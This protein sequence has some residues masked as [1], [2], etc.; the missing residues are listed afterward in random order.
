MNI[1]DLKSNTTWQE[2]SNTINNNNNKISLAI[3]TLENATL[4]NKGYFTTLEKLN[5]A[6][7]NP[8]VGS[9]A[10][11]GT[12]EPYAIYI[13]ENGVWVDSGYTGGDEIVARITTDRI[14]DGAV[15]SEKIATSAFDDTLSVSGKIAPADV[16]G[17]KLNE[18]E[19]DVGIKRDITIDLGTPIVGYYTGSKNKVIGSVE[20]NGYKYNPYSLAKYE[21]CELEVSLIEPS[22]STTR[23]TALCDDSGKIID[24]QGEGDFA[25]N[26]TKIFTIGHNQYLY[27][28]RMQNKPYSVVVK[29][30]TGGI[31][32]SLK[33]T[34]EELGKTKIDLNDLKEYVGISGIQTDT[35]VG[36]YIYRTTLKKLESPN[37][38][39]SNVIE[40]Q[41]GETLHFSCPLN[42]AN[43]VSIL[44][45]C[46]A[47]GTVFNECLIYDTD[48]SKIGICEF[49]YTS[50]THRFVVISCYTYYGGVISAIIKKNVLN[51]IGG[52]ELVRR[53]LN[54]IDEE[55]PL[56]IIKDG[57]GLAG[58]IKSFACIGDSYTEGNFN[59]T[60]GSALDKDAVAYYTYPSVLARITGATVHNIGVSGSTAAH[61]LYNGR[62]I[63]WAKYAEE[64]GFFNENNKA[65][66]YYI[67]LGLND[68]GYFGTFDGDVDTDI[69]TTDYMQCNRETS[70]GAIGYIVG[71]I[72]SIQPN[73]IIFIETTS[74]VVSDTPTSTHYTEAAP[75]IRQIANKLDLELVDME[76]YFVPDWVEAKKWHNMYYN[77]GHPNALGYYLLTQARV[78]Y[79]DW[80][81]RNNPLRY[82][83]IAFIGTDMEYKP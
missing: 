64:R 49:E 6:I 24:F 12:S 37:L 71:K 44:T 70:V 76:K 26:P 80:L 75:K 7:P 72:R 2:A 48:G 79:I 59:R 29:N 41:K 58:Q 42:G 62:Y 51:Y 57:A 5:E 10:Y 30:Y 19:E 22:S 28:S 8:S 61:K 45:D 63:D 15:T 25:N 77:G 31:N 21:G 55:N 27:L 65:V 23:R 67:Y 53:E 46:N 20:S 17:K 47:D 34:K 14:E 38:A 56:A 50:D 73:A 1:Q 35:I 11:V 40:L 13:V 9:K 32:Q 81:M 82:R 18:L 83:E 3:A 39:M 60:N 43:T 74:H 4:K 33:D 68:C 52:V 69:N 36:S 78:T 54:N 16:V 66:A